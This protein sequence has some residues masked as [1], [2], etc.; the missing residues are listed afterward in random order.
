MATLVAKTKRVFGFFGQMAQR[1][2]DTR[3]TRAEREV[4]HHRMFLGKG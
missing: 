2:Y 1:L 4:K 3:L